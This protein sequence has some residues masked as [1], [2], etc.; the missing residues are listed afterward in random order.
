MTPRLRKANT[1]IIVAFTLILLVLFGWTND[2]TIGLAL[3][4]LPLLLIAQVWLVLRD[5]R[6][7]R[8]EEEDRGWYER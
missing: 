6:E 5:P 2:L 7:E 8:E 4:V 3:V 1:W